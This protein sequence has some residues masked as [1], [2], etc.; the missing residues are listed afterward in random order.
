MS[1]PRP[2]PAPVEW[3]NSQYNPQET[4]RRPLPDV[5]AEWLARSEKVKKELGPETVRYGEDEREVADVYRPVNARGCLIFYHGGYWRRCSKDDHAWVARDF[6]Q[7]GITVA[8]MNYPLCPTVSLPD[9]NRAAQ[10]AFTCLYRDHFNTAERAHL[11]VAGHSA[12]GYLAAAHLSE[13]CPP[14]GLSANG[15]SGVVC[16]SPLIDLTPL[17][18]TFVNEWLKL[19]PQL[20]AELSLTS[21][22]IRRLTS[23]V[24][25]T[26]ARE[27]EEFHRQ[28]K[29]L[30]ARIEP[31]R[32]RLLDMPER[33]HFDVLDD[34]AYAGQP[35]FQATMD[36]L[37]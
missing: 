31:G 23:A 8:V 32:S 16:I 30:A 7:A 5:L 3:Y 10:R 11:V 2:T 1:E 37:A 29:E 17:V 36:L 6:V 13:D 18:S 28:A 12:G 24:I 21:L 20:A 14:L 9:I 15:P 25:A 4:S 33:D 22:P 27:S 34:F 19:T 26:G 35:L